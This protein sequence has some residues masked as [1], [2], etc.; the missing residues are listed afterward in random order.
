MAKKIETALLKDIKTL[1]LGMAVTF[2]DVL[3]KTNENNEKLSKGEIQDNK[4]TNDKN[5]KSIIEENKKEQKLTR[6]EL[7]KTNKGLKDLK[8]AIKDVGGDSGGDSGFGI[9]GLGILG[10]L[11]TIST[12]VLGIASLLQG[13]KDW[14][15]GK[16]APSPT[17]QTAANVAS[18]TTVATRSS[19]S[20]ITQKAEKIKTAVTEG[21]KAVTGKETLKEAKI[22]TEEQKIQPGE[23]F[24]GRQTLSD[25]ENTLKN[26]LQNRRLGI[27]ENTTPEYRKHLEFTKNRTA[28]SQ[29][30]IETEKPLSFKQRSQSAIESVKAARA[31]ISPGRTAVTA[32]GA[33]I[34]GGVMEYAMEKDNLKGKDLAAA[35]SWAM[36]RAGL[37]TAA[38]DA[39]LTGGTA[40]ASSLGLKA[41]AAAV[42]LIGWGLV[43]G[44]TLVKAYNAADWGR[45]VAEQQ[46]LGQYSAEL[47]KATKEG[48]EELKLADKLND[49][50]NVEKA[51]Q[52]AISA[53]A[54][55][56]NAQ[57]SFYQWHNVIKT[58]EKLN[59][60]VDMD[61][62]FQN[63][64]FMG[65]DDQ[66]NYSISDAN[67]I[68]Q[69]VKSEIDEG[70]MSNTNV[71]AS[72]LQSLY[73]KDKTVTK[74]ID[75]IGVND[76]VKLVQNGPE[77]LKEYN[78][79][80][81]A[82]PDE[83]YAAHEKEFKESA[84]IAELQ[85][86]YNEQVEKSQRDPY[87]MS[88]FEDE[89]EIKGTPKGSHIIAGEN[90]KSEAIVSTK[91]NAFGVSS[92]IAENLNDM[93][94]SQ[95]NNSIQ[96]IQKTALMIQDAL[97][98]SKN[99]YFDVTKAQ[100]I[101]SSGNNTNN[102]VNNIVAG[103][104]S[105][106][107]NTQFQPSMLTMMNNPELVL[108]RVSYDI[109]KASLL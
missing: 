43:A 50:G 39:A 58:H 76:T 54:K 2:K 24:K 25:S 14:L 75:N 73:N 78:E 94:L 63:F 12:A 98:S 23:E 65:S 74:L 26:R 108:Q 67:S 57:K 103:G 8:E 45:N 85:R 99:E 90:S 56:A 35:V 31:G 81:W 53:V 83:Y 61:K 21:K 6:I 68:I 84:R 4:K 10:T 33:A 48:I 42:P 51:K 29:V 11:G 55:M 38:F 27:P 37:Q 18:E 46:V 3:E 15:D 49:E 96:S 62:A 60:I 40:L 52:I 77:A 5:T 109:N 9:L 80:L 59:D 72:K 93:M 82:K 16:P 17:A 28:Q 107:P 69:T 71:I 41:T 66:Q 92:T 88:R 47:D 34:A 86:I 22:T 44:D 1:I 102:I 101:A 70:D 13:L 36:G 7:K 89:G 97:Q 79:N 91:P 95:T 87:Y 104:G 30:T 105:G 32:G 106:E 64:A 100:P 19:P 20:R